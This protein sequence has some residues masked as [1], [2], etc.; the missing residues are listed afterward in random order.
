MSEGANNQARG[1]RFPAAQEG[2]LTIDLLLVDGF[3]RKIIVTCFATGPQSLILV[4]GL[5]QVRRLGEDEIRILG[6]RAP[7]WLE[8]LLPGWQLRGAQYRRVGVVQG[9]GSHDGGVEQR[10]CG[11]GVD[12]WRDMS[13]AFAVWYR[14]CRTSN[15]LAGRVRG[16]FQVCDGVDVEV[17]AGHDW[18]E[19]F[20]RH[21]AK[22]AN[23]ITASSD[24]V[25]TYDWRFTGTCWH[26]QNCLPWPVPPSHIL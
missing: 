26:R 1:R 25:G 24:G 18:I 5:R 20:Q 4:E 21:Q 16:Q 9:C 11:V 22:G 13:K 23:P 2:I 19:R 8:P 6:I 3:R 12:G 7:T 17:T 15:E 14:L 10:A